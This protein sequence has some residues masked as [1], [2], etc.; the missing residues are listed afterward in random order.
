[1]DINFLAVF[2]SKKGAFKKEEEEEGMEKKSVSKGLTRW[3][4][5]NKD[6]GLDIYLLK[7]V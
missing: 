3:L 5:V 6:R 2:F 7:V 4:E 1:M